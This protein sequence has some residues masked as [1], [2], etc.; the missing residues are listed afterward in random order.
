M[1]ILDREQHKIAIQIP[2]GPQRIRGLAG[3][4]KTVVMCMKAAEMHLRYPDWNIA[5]TFY[6]RSLYAQIKNLITRFYRYCNKNQENT[7]P[8]WQ[9]LHILHGWGGKDAPGLYSMVAREAWQEPR[10]YK[11][12]KNVFLYNEQSELLGSCCREL[13]DTGEQL[14]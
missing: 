6:T 8:N 14:R 13:L 4:G 12:A 7:E 9:K 1:Q 2:P 5:Y 10:T 11:E 3:S